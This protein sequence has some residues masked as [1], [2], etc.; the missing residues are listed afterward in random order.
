[1]ELA[2]CRYMDFPGVGVIDLEVPQ[3]LEK[4]Y[5]VAAER[6]FNKPTIMETIESVSKALHEYERAGGFAPAVAADAEDVALAA[7]VAHVEL[8]TYASASRRSMKV[9][10]RRLPSRS[11]PLKPQPLSRRPV[12]Q[13]PLLGERE[14]HR[15]VRLPQ[16]LKVSSLACSTSWTPLCKSRPPPR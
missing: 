13:K 1:M 6:M 7:P 11:K 3:L 15:P 5:E 8:T 2:T 10:R 16:K 9:E 12:R 4:V 14:R